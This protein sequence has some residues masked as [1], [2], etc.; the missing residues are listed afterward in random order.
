MVSIHP[1]MLSC[2]QRE[3]H[4]LVN[5]FISR[6]DNSTVD[7]ATSRPEGSPFVSIGRE[8]ILVNP[9]GLAAVA[10]DPG[11]LIPELLKCFDDNHKDWAANLVLYG[12]AGEDALLLSARAQGQPAEWRKTQKAVD[13]RHWEQWWRENRPHMIWNG[14]HYEIKATK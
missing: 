12:V 6:L 14:T 10:K 8:I 4:D 2:N 13:R 5:D 7:Y 9:Q 11:L 3:K 1:A